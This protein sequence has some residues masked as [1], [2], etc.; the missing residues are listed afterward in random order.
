MTQHSDRI[1]VIGA[2]P[3]G[4]CLSL[5]LAHA[6]VQVCL[7]EALGDDNFLEQV[8]R[9]GTNHPAT[10]ELYDLIGLYDKIAP[11][12]KIDTIRDLIGDGLSYREYPG[13]DHAT[14]TKHRQPEA[15]Q[16]TIRFL[17]ERLGRSG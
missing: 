8:P 9:A 16:E 5:A 2:G 3:V 1:I 4:L 13:R 17:W 6:G 7:I 15:L 14:L 11:R 12:V 10:L